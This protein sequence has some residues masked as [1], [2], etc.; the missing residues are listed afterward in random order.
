MAYTYKD[1]QDEVK[2][3]SVKDQAGTQ[4]DTAVKNI[5]N[6]SLFRISREAL[7]KPLRRKSKFAVEKTFTTGTISAT[8][9]S[10]S[11]TGSGMNLLTNGIETGRRIDIEGSSLPFIIETITGENAFTTNLA[12]DGTTASSLTHTTYGREEYNLPVQTGR[13]AFLWH[14]RS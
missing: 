4:F 5:I 3:R 8:N 7:W 13:V 9:N 6:T 11:Y 14:F 1:L 2:R 12:Y 10:Q